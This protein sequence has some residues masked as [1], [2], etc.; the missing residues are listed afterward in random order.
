MLRSLFIGILL[1]A[2]LI[3]G[4]GFV[5]PDHAHVERSTVIQAPPAQV[6]GLLDGFRQFDK[7]SPWA[8]KDPQAKVTQSGA[9]FGVGAKYEW[10]GNK[11][12]GSGSQE[13]MLSQPYTHVQTK[14]IFGGFDQPSTADFVLAPGEG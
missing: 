11:D 12:V 7:W 1:L 5:L 13:I 2:V 3:L 10:S 4:I 6:F 14:L 9:L 8:E